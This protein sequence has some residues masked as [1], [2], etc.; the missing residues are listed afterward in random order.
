MAETAERR[1]SSYH[2]ARAEQQ[3]PEA[4]VRPRHQVWQGRVGNAIAA[5]GIAAL[6]IV[7]AVQTGLFHLPSRAAPAGQSPDT[8][9]VVAVGRITHYRDAGAA[10][11]TKPLIDVLATNLGR[12]AGMHVVSAARMYDL[13]SQDGTGRDTSAAG[14]VGAA[15][16]AGA[17][18]L[19]DG[20]LY[21]LAGGGMRLDLR[22]M[23]LATGSIRR[24]YSVNGATLFELADSATARLAADFAR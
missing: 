8:M 1:L 11:L 10:D 16:R 14:V 17:T 12:V 4:V 20:A 13:V 23:E 18:E 21:T 19:V 9:P 3:A 15:R 22:R 6:V 5:V 7:V 2:L 24:T